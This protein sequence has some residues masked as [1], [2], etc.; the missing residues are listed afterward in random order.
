MNDWNCPALVADCGQGSNS[1][2]KGN[3]ERRGTAT[4]GDY[5]RTSVLA[6][7]LYPALCS[8]RAVSAMAA[9][10]AQGFLAGKPVSPH[11]IIWKYV[12]STFC[13][14]FCH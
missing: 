13:A 9:P 3:T 2:N 1:N 8:G 11:P 6:V 5:K 12:F 7:E 14:M 4:T 10:L